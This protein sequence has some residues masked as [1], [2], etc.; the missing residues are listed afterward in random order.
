MA[1][2]GIIVY[3]A[4]G[5]SNIDLGG[6]V[7]AEVDPSSGSLTINALTDV[8]VISL[9]FDLNNLNIPTVTITTPDFSITGNVLSQTASGTYNVDFGGGVTG[10]VSGSV[11][12]NGG[13]SISGGISVTF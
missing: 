10:S 7:S 11:S 12:G 2:W 13:F 5:D 1:Q 6:G 8:G 3:G 9:E 4:D